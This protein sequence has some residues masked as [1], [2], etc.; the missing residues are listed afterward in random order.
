VR[1]PGTFFTH[2]V[3]RRSI[4]STLSRSL[5]APRQQV[6]PHHSPL[7]ALLCADPPVQPWQRFLLSTFSLICILFRLHIVGNAPTACG[8][9]RLS[10]CSLFR[11]SSLSN[12]R[13]CTLGRD[14]RSMSDEILRKTAEIQ[15]IVERISSVR[16]DTT[17]DVQ[18]I[19]RTVKVCSF[20]RLFSSCSI[21]HRS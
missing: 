17:R 6:L 18:D 12:L 20:S 1:A 3:L 2:A 11:V 8:S 19:C 5:G 13:L 15:A 21:P 7:H 14:K 16:F 9:P 4:L 10:S